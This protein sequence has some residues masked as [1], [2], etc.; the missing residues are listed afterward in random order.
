MAKYEKENLHLKDGRTVEIQHCSSEY[1]HLLASFKTALAHETNFT[2]HHPTQESAD[3][4]KVKAAWLSVEQDPN[5]LYLGAFA[6][7]ALA[8]QLFFKKMVPGHPWKD[9]LGYFGMGIRK[10]YWGLRL[11]SYLLNAADKFALKIGVKRIEAYVRTDN[12][13]ALALYRKNG[14]EIDGTRKNSSFVDGKFYDE[15]YIAKLL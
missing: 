1:A 8:G 7:D 2:L 3:I 9:H 6:K 14:Y 5:M 4:E 13:R 15:F 10:E 12:E 11:G